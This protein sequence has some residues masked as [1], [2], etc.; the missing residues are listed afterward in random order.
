MVEIINFEAP[1][2]LPLF[3]ELLPGTPFPVDALG[4]LAEPVRAI[5]SKVQAPYAIAAHSVLAAVTLAVQ[6]HADVDLPYGQTR[7]I[8]LYLLTVAASSDRKTS[9]DN[10]ALRPIHKHEALLSADNKQLMIVWRARHGAWTAQKKK[11]ERDARLSLDAREK[12]L[13]ALGAEPEKPLHPFLTVKDL[14]VEGLVKEMPNMNAS[15]GLFS[16]EGASFIGGYVMSKDAKSRGAAWLSEAW[17][18]QGIRRLRAGDGVSDI[19]GRRLAFHLMIQT[20][21]A[22]D[23]LN[24]PILRDQGFLS[25]ILVAAPESIAGYRPF[26]DT[27]LKDE[28]AIQAYSD[29]VESIL[30]IPLPLCDW[31]N[32]LEPRVLRLSP[33]ARALWIAFHD[34]VEFAQREGCEL[35]MI[36]DFAGKAGENVCRLAS[37]L[38]LYWDINTEIIDAPFMQSAIALTHWYLS[39]AI[40]QSQA[41]WRN[42]ELVKA[43]S[44]LK[45]AQ[46]Q[47]QPVHFNDMLRHVRIRK[48]NELEPVIKILLDYHWITQA[49]ERPRAYWVQQ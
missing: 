20:K 13:L 28:R 31:S 36:K 34:Q 16:N 22:T 8:S 23:F 46:S 32:G 19:H 40:R 33:E 29:R 49:S 45:W 41:G 24:D 47:S 27:E 18:G 35:S 38:A 39:E 12:A 5:A 3:P 7:P 2:P 21:I 10:E 9:T 44:V 30:R 4:A 43:A 48:K 26:R 14:S 11:I 1:Q 15:L 6:G 37:V 42:P 25:R 17:D